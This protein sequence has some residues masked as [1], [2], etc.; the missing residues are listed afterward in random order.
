MTKNWFDGGG[1]SVNMNHKKRT[2]LKTV[3]LTGNRFGRNTKYA[4]C[5]IIMTSRVYPVLSGNAYTDGV[6]VRVK[7]M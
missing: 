1:C 3:T 5:G 4:S 2:D 6:A 7:Y